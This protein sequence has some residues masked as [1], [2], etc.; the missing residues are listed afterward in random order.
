MIEKK[1]ELPKLK[2][3]K[4]TRP[5]PETLFPPCIKKIL[6]GVQDGRKR[7]VFILVNFL[8]SMNWDLEKI[9][10]T[11]FEWNEKNS[12]PLRTNYLRGQLRWHFRQERGLLPPSCDNE[13]FY[14]SMGVCE[15]DELCKGA[16]PVKNP[17]NYPFK[18]LK[19]KI[20]NK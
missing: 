20:K 2:A 4:Q 19:K 12:P 18:K 16:L 11:M 9:E 7:S 3:F 1:E 17:V 15:A 8:R 14:S 13:N 6:K 10:K 5:V